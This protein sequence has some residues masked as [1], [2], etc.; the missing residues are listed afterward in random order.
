VSADLPT[1]L[2]AAV[3]TAR[4]LSDAFEQAGHSFFLVGGVVRDALAGIERAE[5][6][7]D[8]TTDARPERIRSLVAPLADA[9]WDQ[10]ARFGT[11]AC[12]LDG[13]VFEITTHRTEVYDA[14]SRKPTVAFGTELIDD[15]ARRD[16]TVNAMAV[17][18]HRGVV[19]DPFAGA[20]DLRD[21]VLRTPL[22][23]EVAF[24]EDPLRMLRAARFLAGFDL[25][26]TPPLEAAVVALVDRMAIVSAERI[27]DELTKLLLLPDP[28][29]GLDF[30]FRT[31]VMA[32]VLPALAGL[33]GPDLTVPRLGARV[34]AVA[35]E[36]RARWAALLYDLDEPG[37]VL[38]A[39]R[40]SAELRRQVV[41]LVGTRQWSDPAAIPD[42]EPAVR[43]LAASS[44][45]PADDLV[46]FARSVAVDPGVRDGLDGL[47]TRLI[48]VR[49]AEPDIDDPAPLLGG[50]DVIEVL[51]LTPGPEVGRAMAWLREL[52]LAEG[53]MSSTEARDR[54]VEWY[55]RV[56]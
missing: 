24:S 47:A 28:A 18:A 55:S 31:G 43:R 17:D 19:V 14:D 26:P 21:A 40:P 30:L 51:G 13:T 12:R 53:P 54:L 9:V 49:A 6:D 48:E 52:R 50:A 42:D 5:M 33:T 3:A 39:V 46:A 35:S 37:A 56:D 10:G 15:L 45:L 1:P 32:V 27:R 2:T 23:P 44:V 29:P 41:E 16:F 22:E 25:T 8:A 11:V 20:V 38:D 34:A 36:P 4:P 7:L